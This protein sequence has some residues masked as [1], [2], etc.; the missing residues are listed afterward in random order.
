MNLRR[1]RMHNVLDTT[2]GDLIVAL[3]DSA[4]EM[5]D[6]PD[7]RSALVYA[8]LCDFARKEPSSARATL[9]AA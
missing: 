9:L 8:A 4:A 1:H 6:D 7:E 3:Y 5:S 2:V